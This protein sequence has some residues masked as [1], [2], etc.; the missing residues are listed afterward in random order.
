MLQNVSK[1]LGIVNYMDNALNAKINLFLQDYNGVKSVYSWV[2]KEN[3]PRFSA[4]KRDGR[5]SKPS[6]SRISNRKNMHDL[7][8][9]YLGSVN[10][11]TNTT[12]P[13]RILILPKILS[14]IFPKK[15]S[16]SQSIFSRLQKLPKK[17]YART[18]IDEGHTLGVDGMKETIFL[19]FTLYK[20]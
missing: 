8:F 18:Y 3:V 10:L 12:R 7:L 19:H 9:F 13:S 17:T 2:M 20:P 16:S 4:R 11:S 6:S 1:A 5:D 15:H 14:P